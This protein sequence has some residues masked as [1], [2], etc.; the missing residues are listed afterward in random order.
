MRNMLTGCTGAP[1][2]HNVMKGKFTHEF[3][4]KMRRMHKC[5]IYGILGTGSNPVTPILLYLI[6]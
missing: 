4:H 3:T 1:E 5:N 2:T 6:F